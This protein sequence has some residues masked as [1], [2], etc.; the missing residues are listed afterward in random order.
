[1]SVWR[2]LLLAGSTAEQAC[3]RFIDAL[4]VQSWTWGVNKSNLADACQTKLDAFKASTPVGPILPAGEKPSHT[5]VTFV[6]PP[7]TDS[8]SAFWWS[9]AGREEAQPGI[10]LATLDND[11]QAPS[12]S[13]TAAP[14]SGSRLNKLL[15]PALTESSG[16][17]PNTNTQDTSPEQALSPDFFDFLTKTTT[18][19]TLNATGVAASLPNEMEGTT[20]SWREGTDTA[21]WL[22]LFGGASSAQ[23]AGGPGPDAGQP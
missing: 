16:S 7:R 12:A 17:S 15:A 11:D 1:M 22:K 8:N 20:G 3:D 18:T 6:D 2:A 5:P 23:F 13:A 9:L 14:V 21:A 10:Q 4:R 19:A